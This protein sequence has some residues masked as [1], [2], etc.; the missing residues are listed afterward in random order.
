MSRDDAVEVF[1]VE[2]FHTHRFFCSDM[3]CEIESV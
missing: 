3:M 2:E 1:F